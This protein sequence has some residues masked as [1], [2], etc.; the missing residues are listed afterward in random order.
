MVLIYYSGFEGSDGPKNTGKF[1]YTEALTKLPS[2]TQWDNIDVTFDNNRAARFLKR[3]ELLTACA[4]T[5]TTGLNNG[6]LDS[7]EFLFQTSRFESSS[8]GRTAQW[9]EKEGNTLYRIMSNDRRYASPTSD[10]KNAL[11]PVIEVK[12]SAI[13][14]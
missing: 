11:R 13:L 9:L 14:Y 12:K 4:K 5:G 1:V 2:T 8:T 3:S 10:S 6:D 7:C